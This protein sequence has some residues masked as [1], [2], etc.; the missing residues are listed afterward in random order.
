MVT[1]GKADANPTTILESMS[2]GLLPV[3]TPQSG[4][5]GIPS[6]TNIALDDPDEA[7]AVLARLNSVPQE[8]LLA[9]QAANWRLIDE[10]FNWDR[11]A[12]QVIGAIESTASPPLDPEA[13]SRRIMFA[14][15]AHRSPHGPLKTSLRRV[16]R[17]GRRLFRMAVSIARRMSFRRG[18]R[19]RP[20]GTQG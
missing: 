19:H 7:A 4:Y 3:C 9:M 14:F 12:D 6:I 5:A 13:R 8:R 20:K 11:F 1:V 16:N 18:V 2:W 17:I 10:H 15:N